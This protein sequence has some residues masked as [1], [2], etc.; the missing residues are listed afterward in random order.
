[1][2][3]LRNNELFRGACFFAGIM[4]L[5]SL[6]PL[7]MLSFVSVV[8][9]AAFCTALWAIVVGFAQKATMSVI[10]LVAVVVVYNPFS[11]L[12]VDDV[13][14]MRLITVVAAVAFFAAGLRLDAQCLPQSLTPSDAPEP[15]Q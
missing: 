15:E 4:C 13:S 12:F 10:K 9:W 5:L 1:M 14:L 6:A 8:R 3:L 2:K 11:P 7:P